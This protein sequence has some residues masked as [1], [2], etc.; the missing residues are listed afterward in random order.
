[1]TFENLL[2]HTAYVRSVDRSTDPFGGT[3][4]SEHP[5]RAVRCRLDTPSEGGGG[6]RSTNSL[7]DTLF[8]QFKIFVGANAGLVEG[9]HI[10]RIEDS[11]GTVLA[12]DVDVL[13]VKRQD[14]LIGRH[15]YEVMAQ[16]FVETSTV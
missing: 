12:K 11:S 10:D 4:E 13:H 14:G 8:L 1:M 2:I 7:S 15:H 5:E 3:V 9:D 16:S 6:E